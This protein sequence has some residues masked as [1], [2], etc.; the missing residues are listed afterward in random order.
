[1]WKVSDLVADEK[2]EQEVNAATQA[3]EI[4][5]IRAL[6]KDTPDTVYDAGYAAGIHSALAIIEGTK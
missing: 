5:R 4:E 1:M 3:E 6:P 2:S